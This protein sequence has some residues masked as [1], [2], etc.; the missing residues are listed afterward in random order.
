LLEQ[1]YD[2]QLKAFSSGKLD[3]VKTLQAGEYPVRIQWF[4]GNG[5]SYFEVFAT[6]SAANS[7]IV[8][9]ISKAGA[10]TFTDTSG[11]AIVNTDMSVTNVSL[12]GGQF[13][14]TFTSLPGAN[15]IIESS[16]SMSTPWTV[17]NPA[18]ASQGATTTWSGPVN[19]A[20]PP[21]IQFFRARLAP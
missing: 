21:G 10:T 12:T 20:T 11:L 6:P 7:R 5:G 15:Y 18:F 17:V 13:S 4:E 8:R 19:P 1:Y 3:A 9:L 16:T 14:F 2:D